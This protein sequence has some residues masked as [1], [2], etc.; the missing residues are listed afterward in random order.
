MRRPPLVLIF[1][2][3][4]T[5]ITGNTLIAPA[6]PDIAADLH[7]PVSLAG[8]VLSVATLPGI[9]LA[10]LIGLLAD[11]FG[12]RAVLVPCLVLFGLAGGAGGLAPNLPVLLLLRFLQGAGSAGLI[13]L[14]VVLIGDHWDGVERARNLGR[15]AAV[16]T[17]AIAIL[18]PLGGGMADLWSWRAPFGVYTVA[19][20]T[21]V[22]VGRT[23]APGPSR[24]VPIRTALRQGIPALRARPVPALFAAAAVYFVLLFGLNLTVLPVYLDDRFGLSASG[25]GLLLAVPAISAAVVASGSGRW[26]R[27]GQRL[28]LA[29]GILSHAV[30]LAVIAAAPTVAVVAAGGL[31][32]G[33]AEGFVLPTL[34]DA[35]NDAAPP[36]HRGLVVAS[37]VS[38]ARLG[39]TVGPVAAGAVA[40]SVGAQGTFL[41]GTA[42]VLTLMAAASWHATRARPAAVASGSSRGTDGQ[43]PLR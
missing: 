16:L 31:L 11:R 15:N 10:P 23:L 4:A 1:A 21:A 9:V 39:Q 13:N 25:R 33:A 19:L 17:G 18:P 38:A 37:F 8:A 30:G 32:L 24:P 6:I 41:L 29:A 36:T 34:Q 7:V 2:V 14:A 20:V 5:G 26:A 12:R 40:G 35:V 22:V 43:S 3:T 27:W 42:T 28:A